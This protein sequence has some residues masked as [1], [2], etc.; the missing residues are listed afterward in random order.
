MASPLIPTF[1]PVVLF[2]AGGTGVEA[3]G[4]TAMSLT[5]LDLKLASEL[6]KSTRIYKLLKGYR[7]KPPVD[8]KGLRF[9]SSSL[10]P[11]PFITAPSVNSTSILCSWM[12]RA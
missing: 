8:L 5:P 4:D 3:I 6:I 12:K 10:V 1:G 9:A 2:G 11:L 7:D